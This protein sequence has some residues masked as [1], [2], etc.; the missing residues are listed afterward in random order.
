[1]NDYIKEVLEEV[2]INRIVKNKE[3]KGGKLAT[4]KLPIFRCITNHSARYTFINIMLNDFEIPPMQLMKITGQSLEI[5]LGYERGN[6]EANAVKVA[7]RIKEMEM[8]KL[9]IAK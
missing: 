5:L 7:A 9:K 6:K 1:M 3:S 4:T 2:E 8:P